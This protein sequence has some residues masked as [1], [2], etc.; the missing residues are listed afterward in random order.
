V[1]HDPWR[2]LPVSVFAPAGTPRPYLLFSRFQAPARKRDSGTPTR[3]NSLTVLPE[4]R[5]L[6]LRFAASYAQRRLIERQRFPQFVTRFTIS[7][8]S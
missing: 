8:R 6:E 7:T 2:R 3:I 1:L 4:T 5:S